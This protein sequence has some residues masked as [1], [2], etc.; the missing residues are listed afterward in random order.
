LILK[1]DPAKSAQWVGEMQFDA[2]KDAAKAL[3][4]MGGGSYRE[5]LAFRAGKYLELLGNSIFMLSHVLCMFLLGLWAGKRQLF[6]NLASSTA[7]RQRMLWLGALIGMPL[8]AVAAWMGR[9]GFATSAHWAF[10]SAAMNLV[11]APLLTFAYVAWL[12]LMLEASWSRR[13]VSALRWS[14]RMALTNYLTQSLVM[15]SVFY[16][17]G[18][19]LYGQLPISVSLLI[20]LSLACAQVPL[21]RWWLSRHAMGPVEWVW[22]RLTYGRWD[23]CA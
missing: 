13:W 4:V 9:G 15:T 22:R 18:L 17:Y 21:S 12:L 19:G 7:L 3:Q 14:G 6:H 16:G 5:V 1:V 10:L 2:L 20:A 8:C 23:R 11:A